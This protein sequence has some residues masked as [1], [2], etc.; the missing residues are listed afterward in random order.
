MNK[1]CL[2]SP[3]GKF[4]GSIVHK[5]YQLYSYLHKCIAV[6]PKK[7]R[8]TLGIKIEQTALE[9]FELIMLAREKTGMSKQLILKKADFKITMMK[10]FCRLAFDLKALQ[11]RWYIEAEERRLEIGKMLG[12]WFKYAD[13]KSPDKEA[14]VNTSGEP[15]A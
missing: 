15:D 14:L 1:T 13:T 7:D 2:S 6:F 4:S 12:G 8:F 5:T 9:F 10:L 11:E 3:N